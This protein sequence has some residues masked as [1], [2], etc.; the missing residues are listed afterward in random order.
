M[1][2]ICTSKMQLSSPPSGLGCC[3]FEGV[4]S[5]VVDLLY[6]VALIVCVG[7]CVGSMFCYSVL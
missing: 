4:G 5:V 1:T 6:I 2:K 3:P 7:R